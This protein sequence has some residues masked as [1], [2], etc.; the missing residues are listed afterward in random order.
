MGGLATHRRRVRQD[1]PFRE[2]LINDSALV[3]IDKRLRCLERQNRVL[4]ILL[5]A[6]LVTGSVVASN[7]QQSNVSAYEVRAQ[8]F[9]LVDPNGGVADNWYIE[10][11]GATADNSS[12]RLIAPYSGW[13]YYAP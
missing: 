3:D 2:V 8:R 12:R 13:P 6:A 11:S 9:T 4:V 1:S 7:A 5:W 10:P